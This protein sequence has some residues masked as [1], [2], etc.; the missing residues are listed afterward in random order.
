MHYELGFVDN[1]KG[2]LRLP[3]CLIEHHCLTV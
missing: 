1:G 2:K 3:L